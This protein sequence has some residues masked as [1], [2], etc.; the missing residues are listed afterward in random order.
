MADTVVKKGNAA[1][2]EM[3]RRLVQ[4]Q[5]EKEK[6]DEEREKQKKEQAFQRDMDIRKTLSKQIEEKEN[7][8][9]QQMEDNKKL[10][11]MVLDQDQSYNN[12]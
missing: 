8:K 12:A 5:L 3:E 6:R 2:K 11:Q 7:M 9:K 1:E 10:I 4:Q